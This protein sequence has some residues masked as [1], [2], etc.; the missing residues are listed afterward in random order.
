MVM[1]SKVEVKLPTLE[2]PGVLRWP[3]H[4][5]LPCQWLG[6]QPGRTQ[7]FCLSLLSM[8]LVLASGHDNTEKRDKMMELGPFPLLLVSIVGHDFWRKH[9]LWCKGKRGLEASLQG[10]QLF[11]LT[12]GFHMCVNFFIITGKTIKIT[13]VFSVN[14]YLNGLIH[15]YI[16][17]YIY[18]YVHT[19]IYTYTRTHTHID[20]YGGDTC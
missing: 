7:H 10:Q 2:N 18:I 1:V 13:C 3:C 5:T 8:A 19:Y 12:A 15:T 6:A 20:V 17:I 9:L 14:K 16:H 4:W 11:Q